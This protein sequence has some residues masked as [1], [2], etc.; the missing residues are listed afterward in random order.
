MGLD[1]YLSARI[2]VGQYFDPHGLHS[3]LQAVTAGRWP[4]EPEYFELE[5]SVGYW[6]KANQIHEWF[7]ENVQGGEDEC[8][9]HYVSTE[10]LTELRDLCRSLLKDKDPERAKEELPPQSGFFFGGTK[11]D[12]HYWSDLEHTDEQ[13]TKVLEWSDNNMVDFYYRSSW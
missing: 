7:V 11:I 2:Y 4:I 13:L 6:R 12:E 3:R 1:M 8:R 5:A 9:P 10:Q